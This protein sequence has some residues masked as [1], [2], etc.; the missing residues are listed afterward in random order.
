M[1]TFF[2]TACSNESFLVEKEKCFSYKDK[3]EE[4]NNAS[5]TSETEIYSESIEKVFYSPK[6]DSCL[7]SKRTSL[8]RKN[9]PGENG[10]IVGIG[11]YDYLT[12]E[13][14]LFHQ[15]CDAE[16]HCGSSI[17]E[18]EMAFQKELKDYE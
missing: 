6:M 3:I 14:I 8:F 5:F 4:N 11:L 7:Y 10:S 1:T 12:S 2:L 13:R 16:L 9:T 18:A 15:G 17:I